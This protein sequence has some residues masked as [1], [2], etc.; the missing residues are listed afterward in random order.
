M[1]TRAILIA[2]VYNERGVLPQKDIHRWEQKQ[3]GECSLQDMSMGFSRTKWT[4]FLHAA[5]YGNKGNM[6][7]ELPQIMFPSSWTRPLYQSFPASSFLAGAVVT[8]LLLIVFLL[9]LLLAAKVRACAPE[10]MGE[11]M[12]GGAAETLMLT[13]SQNKAKWTNSKRMS[14]LFMLK[15]SAEPSDDVGGIE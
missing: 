7:G 11:G 6:A 15:P 9:L 13:P 3:G 5:R 12:T 10:R 14:Q 2:E 4:P 1:R 8:A